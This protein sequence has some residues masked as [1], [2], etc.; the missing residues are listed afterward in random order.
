MELGTV[1]WFNDAKGYGFVRNDRDNND[2]YVHCSQI[3]SNGFKTLQSGQRVKFEIKP[4]NKGNRG[5]YSVEE[6]DPQEEDLLKDKT[7]AL[8][9]LIKEILSA[10][11]CSVPQPDIN[12]DCCGVT[13]TCWHCQKRKEFEARVK[14]IMER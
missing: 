2:Y 8:S 14:T 9:G 13:I 6:V 4:D 10:L 3:V 1:T 12:N 11:K 7:T 5:C